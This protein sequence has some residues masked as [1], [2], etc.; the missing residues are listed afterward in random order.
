MTKRKRLSK[1]DRTKL[2]IYLSTN[3]GMSSPKEIQERIREH[4]KKQDREYNDEADAQGEERISTIVPDIGTI[5]ED[6]H[7]YE[8][9]VQGWVEDQLGHKWQATVMKMIQDTLQERNNLMKD[10]QELRQQREKHKD[11]TA[12]ISRS[13]ALINK[14]LVENGTHYMDLM[15][16]KPI[17]D[18]LYNSAKELKKQN[19]GEIPNQ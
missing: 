1:A 2:V 6:L 17:L 8:A 16:S 14:Q 11:K 4:M 9:K 7:E 12:N 5:R 15:S 13:I 10:L 3:L 18:E 19:V